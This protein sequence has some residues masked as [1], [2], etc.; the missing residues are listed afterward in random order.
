M[1]RT[2]LR[3]MLPSFHYG[4]DYIFIL[5]FWSLYII[6]MINDKIDIYPFVTTNRQDNPKIGVGVLYLF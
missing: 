3:M 2:V 6:V 1:D 4:M 5:L